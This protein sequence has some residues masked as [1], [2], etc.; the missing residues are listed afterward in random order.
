MGG[1][2]HIV[3][4]TAAELMYDAAVVQTSLANIAKL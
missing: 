4:V 1:F 2:C 3:R